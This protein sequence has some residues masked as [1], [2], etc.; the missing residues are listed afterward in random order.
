MIP[1]MV[2]KQSFSD[3]D[4]YLTNLQIFNERQCTAGEALRA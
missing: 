1:G 4:E 3:G 2:P